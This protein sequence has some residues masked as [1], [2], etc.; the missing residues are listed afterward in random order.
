MG[1]DPVSGKASSRPTPRPLR[2]Q[3][4]ESAHEQTVRSSRVSHWLKCSSRSGHRLPMPAVAGA[5]ALGGPHF[6][7]SFS[8][9][10][11]SIKELKFSIS[12]HRKEEAIVSVNHKLMFGCQTFQRFAIRE[13]TGPR[14][15][16]RKSGH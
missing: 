6:P 7:G 15:D 3:P 10:P 1:L 2:E 9:V 4:A 8:L 13:R 11:Q 5:L 14:Q 12:V 16:S